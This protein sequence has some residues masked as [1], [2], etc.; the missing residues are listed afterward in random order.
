M[1]AAHLVLLV[2][3]ARADDS[4]DHDPAARATP[5][6]SAANPNRA[7][8]VRQVPPTG[9]AAGAAAPATSPAPSPAPPLAARNPAV[10]P[11]AAAPRAA[12]VSAELTPAAA[13][14]T[15]TD[16]AAPPAAGAPVP[17]YSTHLPP[18]ATLHYALNRTLQPGLAP[19]RAQLRWVSDGS[20]YTLEL[21]LGGVERELPGRRSSGAVDAHGLAPERH[22]ETRR[23]REQRAAS[24][25]RDASG[26]GRVRF[27][28]TGTERPL[29]P[30]AQDRLSW[31]LQLAAIVAADPARADPGQRIEIFVVGARGDAEIWR[32]EAMGQERVELG[33][34]RS[35]PALQLRREPRR[36]Y[37]TTA[38]VWL[39]P[40]I[41]YL[42]VR[43]RLFVR[44]TGEGTEFLLERIERP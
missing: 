36:P 17:T 31:M 34:G 19:G 39:A 10:P 2:W 24:F 1:V 11:A 25:E 4:R 43:A 40:E 14:D 9:P 37:D 8:T 15:A 38:E 44:P 20:R 22:A 29:P 26:G 21:T 42:P 16:A 41:G 32:F 27:S 33:D 13:P 30:G 18:T 5:W 3:I 23:G 28:A 7:V 6:Q 12:T 35:V